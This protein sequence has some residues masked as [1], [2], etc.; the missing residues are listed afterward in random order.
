MQDER[1]TDEPGRLAALRRYEILDTPAEAPFD[2]VV[3]LLRSVLAVPMG[4]VSFIDAQREWMK[5]SAGPLPRQLAREH[6]FSIEAIRQMR[7]MAVSDAR[8]DGRFAQNPL[9]VGET[10]VRSY[11]GVP[12]TTPDGYNIGALCVYDQETRPFDSREASILEKFAEIVLEQLDLRQIASQDALTGALS[13]RA[14]TAEAEKEFV[15][16]HRYERPSALVMLDVDRFKDLNARHGYPAGDAV[17]VAIANAVMSNMR[18]TDIFG[19]IGGEEFA[20]MLPETDADA[21]RDAAERIR[22]AIESTIV[23]TGRGDVR[24][25]VSLGVAPMP[26]RPVGVAGW[27]SEAEIALYEAKRLGR[28]RVL[29]ADGAL[30]GVFARAPAGAALAH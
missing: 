24:A 10:H 17:L 19:R 25:T 30:P 20:L 15:R 27:L 1:L 11:L 2:R 5:A 9:L 22:S 21:A 16:A 4:A 14:F 8:E 7:P 13:R 3:D 18:K 26:A 28:N 23:D 29:V 6:S 12:L